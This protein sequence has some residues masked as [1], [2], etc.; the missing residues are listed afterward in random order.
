MIDI[1]L[2]L[3]LVI[4]RLYVVYNSTV[5]RRDFIQLNQDLILCSYGDPLL[6]LIYQQALFL[7]IC[8]LE[9]T[10]LLT[11]WFHM[12]LRL[13]QFSPFSPD[14]ELK[15][16]H[17]FCKSLSMALPP[18]LQVFIQMSPHQSILWSSSLKLHSGPPPRELP[19]PC[20][21]SIFSIVPSF[22]GTLYTHCVYHLP[23]STRLSTLHR[24]DFQSA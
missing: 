3:S 16:T 9:F 8:S 15:P 21:C 20:S 5:R 12:Y 7:R 10:Y 22:S 24:Q 6:F 14:K 11:Y 18:L 13:W 2:T 17:N 19:A 23:S 4:L 1:S